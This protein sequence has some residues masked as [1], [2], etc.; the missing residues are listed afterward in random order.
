VKSN[1]S[2][3]CCLLVSNSGSVLM[4][5]RGSST[6]W[7]ATRATTNPALATA[8]PT[9][10]ITPWVTWYGRVSALVWTRCRRSKK[11][12]DPNSRRGT[13]VATSRT[14]RHITATTDSPT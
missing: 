13:R 4:A 8:A 6:G 2:R 12:A 14:L 7:I 5:S 11:V 3:L 9:V 1:S 10:A